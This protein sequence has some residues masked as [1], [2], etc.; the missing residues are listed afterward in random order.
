[1]RAA[2]LLVPAAIVLLATAMLPAALGRAFDWSPYALVICGCVLGF[3]F[4][5]GSTL[6][7]WLTGPVGRCERCNHELGEAFR[8]TGCGWVW[9]QE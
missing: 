6:V 5:V 2:L 1:M 4:G 9:W 8:C 7:L 3:S